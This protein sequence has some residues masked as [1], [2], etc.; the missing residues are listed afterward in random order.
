M[1]KKQKR[2]RREEEKE[3][4]K[5]RAIRRRRSS[6]LV[7]GKMNYTHK[8]QIILKKIIWKTLKSSKIKE[9]E[10]KKFHSEY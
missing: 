9:V 4:K 10:Q 2:R 5:R 8:F 7:F 6:W 3:K 1:K